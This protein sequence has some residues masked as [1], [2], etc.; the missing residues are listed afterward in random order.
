M[1]HEIA[2]ILAT[3]FIILVALWITSLVWALSD[4]IRA[5]KPIKWAALAVA[6]PLFGA[7]LYYLYAPT[8]EK[9]KK[10][11]FKNLMKSRWTVA[12]IIII[13][14]LSMYVRLIDYRWP[15]LRNID[16]Y[17]FYRWMDE[18]VI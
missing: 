9:I 18:T 7:F 8:T 2:G 5:R 14:L 1:T 6:V 16:S 10:R 13:M 12:A 3:S 11:K 17:V 15:Y 4:I